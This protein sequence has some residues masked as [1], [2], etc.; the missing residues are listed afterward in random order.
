[1]RVIISYPL[2]FDNWATYRPWVEKFTR[3]FQQFPPGC[4][5]EVLAVCNWGEPTDEVREWFYGIKTR[6]IPYFDNGCDLGGHQFV[7]ETLNTPKGK[8]FLDSD[9]DDSFV[10]GMTSRCFFHR[11]G[12]LERLIKV[13]K[14]K[15]PGIFFTSASKQ[16]GTLHGCTRAF[17][18]D[19][20]IWRAYPQEINSR[21][22]GPYFEVGLCNPYG[23]LLEWYTKYEEQYAAWLVHWDA[24]F[25]LPHEWE[26]YVASKGRFRD[27][28]QNA[29]LVHDWHSESYADATPEEKLK[30]EAMLRGGA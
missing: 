4:D 22:L 12:W 15:G 21:L 10:I 25:E 17:G 27:G 2:P 20:S 1:M 23:N 9:S 19:A 5:Y 14:E 8:G 28:E 3:R 30:L 6:F 7:A 11:A 13:R 26:R 24:V 18:M 29:M 16:G